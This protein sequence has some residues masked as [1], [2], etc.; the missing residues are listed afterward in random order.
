MKN[1]KNKKNN[2]NQ[3]WTPV[4]LPSRTGR[5][6]FASEKR[7]IEIGMMRMNTVRPH[8]K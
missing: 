7:E 4:Y 3:I 6:N 2:N 8:S 5:E 1:N